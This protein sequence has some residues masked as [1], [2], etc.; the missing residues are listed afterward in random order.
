[1]GAMH[2]ARRGA[3][4]VELA[5]ERC[6]HAGGERDQRCASGGVA[7]ANAPEHPPRRLR[8]R[9]D[10]AVPGGVVEA[11]AGVPGGG[12]VASSSCAK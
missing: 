3:V 8:H 1:M 12:D 2:H 9:R 6:R 5:L 7:V 11:G 10:V 4:G